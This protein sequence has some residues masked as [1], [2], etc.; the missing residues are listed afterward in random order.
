MVVQQ[1]RGL[2]VQLIQAA[3]AAVVVAMQAHLVGLA[4]QV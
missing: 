2:L 3:V 1:Q 4:V